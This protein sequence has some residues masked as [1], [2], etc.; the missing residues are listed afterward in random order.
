MSNSEDNNN[1]GEGFNVPMEE[2]TMESYDVSSWE[3]QEFIKK[4]TPQ[5]SNKRK[6]Y[7]RGLNSSLPKAKKPSTPSSIAI[8]PNRDFTV[9]HSILH[10]AQRQSHHRAIEDENNKKPA[11]KDN[12]N[13]TRNTNSNTTSSNHISNTTS[14]NNI[15]NNNNNNNTSNNSQKDDKDC[16]TSFVNR[17]APLLAAKKMSPEHRLTTHLV[18]DLEFR[19]SAV[20]FVR[21]MMEYGLDEEDLFQKA[22]KLATLQVIQFEFPN[23]TGGKGKAK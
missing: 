7:D 9:F 8:L 18:N 22:I 5:R 16:I 23:S 14:S 6:E 12:N 19:T 21:K 1:K 13:N 2:D 15:S 17:N 11:A 4:R 3:T 10:E 20:C